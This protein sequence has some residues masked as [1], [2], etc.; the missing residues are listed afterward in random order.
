MG[1]GNIRVHSWLE[2]RYRCRTCGRTF[3]TTTGTPFYRG[4]TAVETVTLVVTVLAHGCP[5]QAI[6]AVFGFEERTV[7]AG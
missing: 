7:A 4:Q 5:L 3:A 2:H 1:W 6:V